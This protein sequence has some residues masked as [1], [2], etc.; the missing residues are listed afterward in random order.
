MILP[1]LLFFAVF[2]LGPFCALVYYSFLPY[3][4]GVPVGSGELTLAN[5]HRFLSD[6]W[7]WGIVA[8]SLRV[9]VISTALTVVVGF[10][11]A[12]WLDRSVKR[13]RGLLIGLLLTPMLVS[14]VVQSYGWLVLL[15]PRGVVNSL[16]LLVGAVDSP[17]KLIFNEL[18]IVL[19]LA[20]YIMPF[21]VL[22]ILTSLQRI[23]RSLERA[24]QNLGA[25]RRR[26]FWRI[27]VPLAMPGIIAG[28]T[29]AFLLALTALVT[30][31][32]MGGQTVITLTVLAY[33][34]FGQSFNWPFGSTIIVLLTVG[35]LLLFALLTRLLHGRQTRDA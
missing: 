27:T 12:Y 23:D 7:Y 3:R 30:P 5:Y 8:T 1:S 2:F 6:P 10:G 32:L 15:S 25:S 28:G 29:L 16:L 19:G 33:Q 13:Y 35:V 11:I 14:L 20:Q 31:L 21:T 24:A 22:S 4:P 9:S 17:V 34:Q 26:T 18:G